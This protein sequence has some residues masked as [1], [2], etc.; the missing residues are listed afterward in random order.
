MWLW[1]DYRLLD[2][3]RAVLI[4][5]SDK[6]PEVHMSKRRAADAADLSEYRKNWKKP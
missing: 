2:D 3:N 5:V 4:K 1:A 6:R